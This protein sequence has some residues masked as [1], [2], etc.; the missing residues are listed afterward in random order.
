MFSFKTL[1]I[2]V[3]RFV[4]VLVLT[5]AFLLVLE[6][7]FRAGKWF[8][9]YSGWESP[10]LEKKMEKARDLFEEKGR[11]D[12]V[13]LSTSVGRVFDVHQWEEA[14]SGSMVAY[15][16]GFPDQ[17]P[18]RQNFLFRNYIHPEFKPSHVVYGIS[19][20]DTNSNARGMHPERPREGPFWTY[21]KVRDIG[22][23]GL[24]DRV[25]VELENASSLFRARHRA[26]FSLQHGD[27]AMLPEDPTIG[28]GVIV[29]TVR[30]QAFG[31]MPKSWALDPAGL[32]YNAYHNYWIPDEGEIG[33]LIKLGKYCQEQGVKMVVVEVPTSPYAHTNFDQADG[34]DR[35]VN[36]LNF[37]ASKGIRVLPM[38]RDLKLDNT[39]FEDQDHLNRWGGQMVTDYV[40]EQVIREWYPETQAESLPGPVEISLAEKVQQTSGVEVLRLTPATV[41]A[42]YAAEKQVL[43]TRSTDIEL[44]SRLAAGSYAIEIYAGDGTTTAPALTG[45]AKLELVAVGEDG[46]VSAAMPIDRWINS[47]VGISYTQ[48][49]FTVP[50]PASLLLRV[51]EVGERPL[52]LDT[53]FIRPRLAALGDGVTVE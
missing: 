13:V 2:Q 8:N 17:R 11:L 49:N 12:L 35:F 22:A 16:F 30:R 19:P 44:S 6:I 36:A 29:P 37:V 45:E 41:D 15:N 4:P 46:T 5:A 7:T 10:G 18:E 9:D 51:T 1:H 39:Y 40:Y 25:L 27:I 52:I 48:V 47:R 28:S 26:R 38:A 34:Y 24:I 14:T 32:P 53:V 21:R 23:E 3:R 43:I 42:Q 31:P 20:P 50:E 33:E